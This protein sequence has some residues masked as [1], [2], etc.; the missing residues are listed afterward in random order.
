MYPQEAGHRNGTAKAVLGLV[1]ILLRIG[2][3]EEAENVATEYGNYCNKDQAVV[4]EDLINGFDDKKG[5]MV[6][7]FLVLNY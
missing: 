5:E 7:N 2:E 4:I 3:L 1:A 6:K